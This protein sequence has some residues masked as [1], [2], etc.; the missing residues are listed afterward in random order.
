M[1][2]A[3]YCRLCGFSWFENFDQGISATN[4]NKKSKTCWLACRCRRLS[5]FVR[6]RRLGT[7]RDQQPDRER[8]IT[9][10]HGWFSKL[11]RIFCDLVKCLYFFCNRWCKPLEYCIGTFN[12][13]WYCSANCSQVGRKA[14]PEDDDDR[15]G[16]YGNDLVR[17]NDREKLV[18]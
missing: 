16:S 15:G 2:D 11:N 7:D 10:I 14:A 18:T 6:R 12:R 1:A 4:K 8:Q 9:Q 5:R 3:C 13:R 17:E